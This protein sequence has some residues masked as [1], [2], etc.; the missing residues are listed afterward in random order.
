MP[1]SKFAHRSNLGYIEGWA[2]I[3]VNTIL[4]GLKY[5]AGIKIGSV[6]MVADSWHTLSD[7]LTSAVVIVGFFIAAKPSDPKHPFGHARAESIASLIIGVL[8]GVVGFSFAV[9]SV[10]RLLDTQSVTF[11]FF[12]IMVF[13]VSIIVK[14][15]LARFA[16]W[17]GKKA[18]ARS[19]VADGWHHRSDAIAS[20]L[21]VVGALFGSSLWWMDGVLG[22]G[23]SLLILYAAFDVVRDAAAYLLGEAHSN[24]LED[25]IKRLIMQKQSAVKDVHHIHVH[26][27]GVHRE[28]TLHIRLDPQ[29]HLSDAHD[30]TTEIEMHLRERMSVTAT[31]HLEPFRTEHRP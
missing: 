15:G 11:N 24:E 3:V 18:K 5:W 4:F 1:L 30:I 2:S 16:F 17:A 6:S 28:I 27:Y 19:I 20:A 13:V 26:N 31:V 29:M 25:E 9:E 12:G 14:E 23:V 7:T 21:I 10:K 22:I 8:L